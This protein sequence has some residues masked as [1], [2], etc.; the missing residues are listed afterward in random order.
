MMVGKRKVAKPLPP[1]LYV[2]KGKR[3]TSY[4]TITRAN[5]YI[6]LGRDLVAAKRK[7]AEIEAD[8]PVSGSI[9]ELIADTIEHRRRLVAQ[10]KLSKRTVDDNEKEHA[11]N[12]IDAFG[13]MQ[14]DALRPKHVWYYLHKARGAEAPVRANKEISFLQ[15][16]MGRACSQ[17]IIDVNPCVGVE[18]NKETPRDRLVSD[19]ELRDFLRLA[20]EDG[21]VSIRAALAFYIAFI[22]GKGQGQ[23]LKLSRRQLGD[24][25]IDFGSRKGGARVLV[26]WSDNL[27]AAID[28]SLAMPAAI[29]PLYVVHT[30]E[31][32]PYTSDGFKKGWQLLMGKWVAGGVWLDGTRREPGERFTFHD[33]RAKAVTEVIEEGRKA[34]EL[35]GHRL[36]STVA[37][38]YDRRRVRT[39]AP[40]R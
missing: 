5:K 24:E 8:T 13:K 10:G 39:A 22:T 29:T 38:V 21:D 12:L 20:R 7:L 30:Q 11:P 14:P 25:G 35:T 2:E 32:G 31:G 9:A 28:E 16:V 15:V 23:I 26:Q 33:G 27:R 19:D 40:V 3:V 37:K 1:R 34:S 18:R 4:Y 17:G 6:G 36:E